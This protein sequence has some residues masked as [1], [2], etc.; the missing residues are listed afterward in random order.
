MKRLNQHGTVDT[1]LVAFSLTVVLF[2]AAAGFGGWAFM[3]RNDFKD[4]TDQKIAEALQ[5][6]E[7]DLTAKKDAEFFEKEKLPNKTYVGPEAYGSVSLIYPKTWSSYVDEASRGTTFV[8]S[9]FHPVTIPGL[10]SGT[11]F[12]LRMQVVGGGYTAQVNAFAQSIKLGKVQ[13]TAYRPPKVDSIAGVRIDGEII[14]GKQG[15]L[16]LLPIR[17]K[18]LKIWTESKQFAG[19]LDNTVLANLTFVP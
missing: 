19:D 8:D 3:S 5:A 7:K 6:A 14:K 13:V 15:I 12:A 11:N 10:G 16:I 18:T 9:Y 1:W 4:N 2:I 17:D